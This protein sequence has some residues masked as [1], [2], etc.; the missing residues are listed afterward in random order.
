MERPIETPAAPASTAPRT[1]ESVSSS[2]PLLPPA[3]STG[4]RVASTTRSNDSGS[5]E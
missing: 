1:I 3:M 4:R 5:P 2:V